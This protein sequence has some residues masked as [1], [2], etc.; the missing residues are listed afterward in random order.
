MRLTSVNVGKRQAIQNAK[1]SGYTGIFKEPASS[2]VQIGLLGLE[3]DHIEDK[4][5]HGGEDQAVYVYG[6]EDHAWWVAELG[7]DLPPGTFGEN[8]TVS[9]LVSADLNIGDTLH[10][11][12]VVLQV[13]SPRIPCI[14]L[15]ARM[16]DPGFVKRFRHAEHPGL[17]CRVLTSGM[18]EAG[19]A[20]SIEV[21]LGET[22]SVREMFRM[23]YDRSPSDAD[24]RRQ[25]GAPIAIRDRQDI[26]KRLAE[27]AKANG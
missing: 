8:L 27:R 1:E 3:H 10:I 9:E 7:R 21:Y 17:Y 22:L 11:G 14:T 2:A 19:D 15:A 26:E 12:E 23:W 13:T 20:V 25:L 16:N 6:G 5:N 4:E 24:L 18:V